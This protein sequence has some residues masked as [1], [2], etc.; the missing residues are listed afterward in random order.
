MTADVAPSAGTAACP[1]GTASHPLEMIPFFRRFRRS[2][3]RDLIYS[4]IWNTLF[5]LFFTLIAI[6]IDPRASIGAALVET[7]V[8][9]QCIGFLIFGGFLVGDRILGPGIHQAGLGVRAAYYAAIPSIAI[10]PGYLLAFRILNWQHGGEWLFSARA[11]VSIVAVSLVLTAVMLLIFLPRERAARAEATI[12]HEQA[13]VAAAER[14][15]TMARLKL[16]EAQVEPHF[17]HN[18]LA[19]VVSLVDAEP[20]TAK[21][22]IERLITLLRAT[23]SSVTGDGSLGA[24][25]NLLRAYLGIL[26]MRMG[27][28]LAWR[29]DVPPSLAGVRVPPML[30]QPVVENAIKHG[31]EPAL[32]GGAI[33]IAARR[34]GANIVLTVTDTGR[35]F[36]EMAPRV[37]PGIGLANLRAR[38]GA[39]YGDAA[40]LTIEDH[41]PH[42][43]RVT[44][45]L[46]AQI[47]APGLYDGYSGAGAATLA[48]TR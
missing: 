2:I 27:E 18:T 11:V 5:G 39:A 8:F 9:A 47:A 7:F 14:A 43:T 15:A 24:Q 41:A 31:L 35:G 22:M 45:V 32:A 12:A 3:A 37:A 36:A 26:E 44:I 40:S 20:G 13:R 29:I 42:G 19:H 10:F 1:R 46:P 34:D 21:Q 23:A 33:A 6:A 17:L 25:L 38:L 4:L 30:L 48:T 28:R 16:L